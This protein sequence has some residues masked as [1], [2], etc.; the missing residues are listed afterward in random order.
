MDKLL[1]FSIFIF[2][3]TL[4]GTKYLKKILEYKKI[5]DIPNKRSSHIKPIATGGGWIIVLS[6]IG[7][8]LF[9][10][11]YDKIPGI[12]AI[13]GL[14]FISWQ[15]DLK[16]INVLVRLL[17]QI[18]FISIYFIY[19]YF[20][21]FY[22][23]IQLTHIFF[24]ILICTW[25]INIFNFMDGIDGISPIMTIT[26]CAGIIIAHLLNKSEYFPTFEILVIST[27]LAFLY[28]NWNPAKIFLGDVGSIVLGFIC[29]LSL[30]WLFL[31][32]NTWHWVLSL[33]MYY[34]LDTTLTLIIRLI[35]GK[36]IWEAHREHYYQKAV[37][38]GMSHS[39]V[40]LYITMLQI[41]I[42]FTC[43]TIKNQYL[44]TFLA[45]L[46]SM[47]LIIYFSSKYKKST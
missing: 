43:Y 26:I 16:N 46:E 21:G 22:N 17:F 18:F 41:L 2:L 42:I 37:Q 10:D 35:K 13:A 12:I 29:I 39:Q 32:G 25:F 30:Y 47:V 14:A 5:F 33:P 40:V 15:D 34:I 1:I 28:W 45:F 38:S 3:F 8:I 23:Q 9:L 4:I 7:I 20:F 27:C 6:I 11:P 31:E 36:K 44:V 24:V 19:L